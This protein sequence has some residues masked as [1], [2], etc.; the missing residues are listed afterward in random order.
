MTN[1]NLSPD[2][3]AQI[4]RN[5]PT[6]AQRAE[7]S[8]GPYNVCLSYSDGVFI[9]T[10]SAG[11]VGDYD[12][13]GLY[14]ST[15]DGNDKYVTYQWAKNGPFYNTGTYVQSGYQARYLIWSKAAKQYVVVASTQTFPQTQVCSS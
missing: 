2:M 5:H 3:A 4:L 7:V 1:E 10:W 14:S 13:V 11:T 15:D 9:M 12:W 6:E 8:E